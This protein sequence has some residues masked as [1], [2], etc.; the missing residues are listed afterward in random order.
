MKIVIAKN[1]KKPAHSI[2]MKADNTL[3]TLREKIDEIDQEIL[4]LL[5]Q[6]ME[7]A[8]SVGDIKKQIEMAVE[9]KDREQAI[10]NRLYGLTDD[11]LTRKQIKRIFTSIFHTAKDVQKTEE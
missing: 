10:L 11:P 3:Q 9:D 2:Q 1:H 8:R 4:D 5:V 7:V 6:R